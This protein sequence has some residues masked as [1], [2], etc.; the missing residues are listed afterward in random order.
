VES[1]RG[2]I[3][4]RLKKL[5]SENYD[6][7]LLAA[8][9][10][11]RMG[12]TDRVS[13]F[14]TA[15]DCVPAVGQGALGLECRA[16]DDF[17]LDLL[18]RFQHE[19]TARCV[20]AERSFLRSLHGGCQVPIGAYGRIAA[21]EDV[22]SGGDA[23]VITLTGIVGSPDGAELLRATVSGTLPEELGIELAQLLKAQ[24]AERIL[25]EVRG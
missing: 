23:D 16:A 13:A 19:A 10:L 1:I 2:N 12:W 8:A 17:M 3:D 21:P 24:G 18:R 20:R 6:A 22:T 4:S 5:E 7:I 25:A 15:D 9:G 11:H 14:L